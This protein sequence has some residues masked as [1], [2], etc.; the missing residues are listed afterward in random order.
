MLIIP[1]SK[2]INWQH[3]PWATI[4]IILVCV[5]VYFV[6]QRNDTRAYTDARAYYVDS[7]LAQIELPAYLDYLGQPP[8]SIP[9]EGGI[10]AEQAQALLSQ[11]ERDT[12]FLTLLESGRIIGPSDPGYREWRDMRAAYEAG[13]AQCLFYAYGFSP[14]RFKAVTLLTAMFLHASAMHVIGNMIFLWLVGSILEATC[15]R[16][17]YISLYVATGIGAGLFFWLIHMDST[18]PGIGAS[19][20]ISGMM[21]AFAW[22]YGKAKIRVFYSLGFVFGTLNIRGFI[23]FLLWIGNEIVGFYLGSTPN[24]GYAAHIGGLISGAAGAVGLQKFSG[25][26]DTSLFTDPADHRIQTLLARAVEKLGQLET[27]QARE[28]LNEVLSMDPGNLRAH[29]HLFAL[30]KQTPG[31]AFHRTTEAYLTVLMADPA[32]YP[33]ACEVFAAYHKTAG[34]I[35]LNTRTLIRMSFVLCD[36]GRPGMAGKLIS[37]LAKKDLTLPGLPQALF[38][39]ARA[40][41]EN[42]QPGNARKCRQFLCRYFPDSSEALQLAA[43]SKS[44]KK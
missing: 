42:G 10:Q 2:K 35:R 27:D 20:A 15:G 26:V 40:F 6:L 3:P 19:G 5:F 1:L 39:V 34:S 11:M 33:E 12:T 38:R 18:V 36:A 41:G 24:V 32:H 7:G 30:D 13:K 8:V 21:G 17:V 37:G 9:D 4:S 25:R 16:V 23:L 28:L 43:L 22:L 31:A 14:A 29:A 44:G